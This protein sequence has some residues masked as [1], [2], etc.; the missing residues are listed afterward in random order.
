M[1]QYLD[2]LQAILDNGVQTTDRTG[3]GTMTLPGYHY[4]VRLDQ[5]EQGVIHGFPLLTT[6]KMSLKSV[7]EELIWKLRG[8]TNIRFLIEH[9]NH[10]WTEWP[11]KHWLQE[12]D[13]TIFL[14]KMWKDEQ[15][16]DYSD[17]WKQKKAEFESR[18]LT[19]ADFCKE[20]GELGKTYGHQFRRFGEVVLDDFEDDWR[21]ELFLALDGWPKE[22][23]K[24]KDQLMQAIDLINH[25]PDNRRII[26]S[27]W[28]PQDEDK[29]LLPPCPC[30]YQF[31][32]NQEGYLHLNLY[33][34]SCD[35]FLGVP[36]NT[37]QDALFLCLMAQITGRKPGTFNHFFGDAHIYLNHIDQV[38]QQLQRT[39]SELPSIRL[40]PKIKNIL[41]FSWEDIELLN[42]APQ[43][44]IKG[45]V[46][47][48]SFPKGEDCLSPSFS[49]Q[50]IL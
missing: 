48:W 30:F 38:R 9:K 5:D 32:A 46:S 18:I 39:P 23:I 35:S 17:I 31:F 13:Q 20:W 44:H 2:F 27:L 22:W 4:Q 25:N 41:D 34:R 43:G 36:Y 12:T 21:I 42:Y 8:D 16:S 15:K 45:A 24:G 40:N 1:K 29:S 14:D 3:T 7:F 19:D 26:I 10:I 6:K 50:Q 33:Q 11:F 47:I 49:L 37:A 28:N